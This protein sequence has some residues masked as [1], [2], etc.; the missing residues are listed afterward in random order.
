MIYPIMVIMLFMQACQG[1]QGVADDME[2]M[3]DDTAIKIEVSREALQKET[4]LK[5]TIEVINKD[6][7]KL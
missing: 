2:K 6:E 4:D 3:A 5:M 7:P 1:F